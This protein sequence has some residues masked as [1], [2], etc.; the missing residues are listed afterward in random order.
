MASINRIADRVALLHEKKF[1]FIGTIAEFKKAT[2][3]LVKQFVQGEVG[4]E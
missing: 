3:P 1:G 2:N 4:A